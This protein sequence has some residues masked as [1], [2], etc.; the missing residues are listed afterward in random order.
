MCWPAPA[1]R[2]FARGHLRRPFRAPGPRP[3]RSGRR[4]GRPVPRW[5]A[6]MDRS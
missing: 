3:L 4:A 5:P 1:F 2:C 6:A